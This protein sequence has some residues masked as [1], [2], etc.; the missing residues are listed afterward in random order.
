MLGDD[1]IVAPIMKPK[2]DMRMIYLPE[3][4]WIDYFTGEKYEGKKYILK[5]ARLDELP[6][7]V[8]EGAI[9]LKNLPMQNIDVSKKSDY[10]VHFYGLRDGEAEYYFDDGHTFNYRSGKYSVINIKVANMNVVF[11][12]KVKGH[13]IGSFTCVIHSK[14]KMKKIEDVKFERE[15]EIN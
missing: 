13:P 7:F 12:H 14:G 3:G 4:V 11:T 1:F 9:I 15:Y 6:L 2:T 8:R 5:S 10:E